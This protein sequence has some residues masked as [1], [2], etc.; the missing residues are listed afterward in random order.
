MTADYFSRRSLLRGAAA[1]SGFASLPT[2]AKE[3]GSSIE[4]VGTADFIDVYR[5]DAG[6]KRKVQS[7]ASQHPSSLT[8]DITGRY[9]FAVNKIDDFQGLPT[10]SVESYRVEPVTGHLGLVSRVPLSLSATM[11]RQ[12]ALSPDGRFLVVAAYGGGLYNVLPVGSKGEIGAVTQLIKE[13]GCSIKGDRQLSS[14]PHSV[15]FHPSGKFLFGTDEGAD[16]INVF[17]FDHGSLTCVQRVSTVPG[18]GPARLAISSSGS[19]LSIEH[20]FSTSIRRYRFHSERELL[21]A[22]ENLSEAM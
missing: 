10:G 21:T 12:L 22:V 8:L 6:Q 1:L 13:I 3:S 2:R 16:R 7:V 15:V 20:A 17:R 5:T 18:S 9:L 4:Y 14:H 11:P 19:H